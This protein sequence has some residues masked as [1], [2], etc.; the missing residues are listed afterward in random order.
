MIQIKWHPTGVSIDGHSESRLPDHAD[1][2]AHVTATIHNFVVAFSSLS[3]KPLHAD[4]DVSEGGGHVH[5]DWGN[6]PDAY[7]SV[8]IQALYIQLAKLA[9]DCSNHIVFDD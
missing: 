8:L 4:G 3:D 9:H 1:V 6:A 5:V 2:C 7:G